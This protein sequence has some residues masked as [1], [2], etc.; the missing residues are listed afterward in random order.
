MLLPLAVRLLLIVGLVR[1][2][3]S[4]HNREPNPR[5]AREIL[6]D[7]FSKCEIDREG[8]EM[9]RKAP[10]GRLAATSDVEP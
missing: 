8:Y 7:R 4:N 9:R 10:N 6:D 1:I 2:Y 5:T 3:D